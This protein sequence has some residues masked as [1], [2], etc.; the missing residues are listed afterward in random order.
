MAHEKIEKKQTGGKNIQ[1]PDHFPQKSLET[2]QSLEKQTRVEGLSIFFMYVLP[3]S[4]KLI[5]KYKPNGC[6]T[7]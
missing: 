2:D 4:P 6:T 1:F 5:L 7:K 3:Y